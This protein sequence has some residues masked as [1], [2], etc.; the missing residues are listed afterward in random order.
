MV[1]Y[2]TIS[3]DAL[4][5]PCDPEPLAPDY[6]ACLQ[7]M[8]DGTSIVEAANLLGSTPHRVEDLLQQACQ[9]LDA[10]N[11]LHAVAIGIR[12]KIID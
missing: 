5:A 8:A 11:V 12:S 7:L 2:R 6:A 9:H 1:G 10:A 3:N 4:W